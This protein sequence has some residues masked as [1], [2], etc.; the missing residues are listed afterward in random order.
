MFARGDE[1]PTCEDPILDPSTVWSADRSAKLRAAEQGPTADALDTDMAAWKQVRSRACAAPVGNREPRIACLDGVLA[2]MATIARAAERVHGAPNVDTGDLLIDPAVCESVRPPRLVHAGSD[3]LVDIVVAMLEQTRARRRMTR[4]EAKTL[5]SR[6][7]SEPCASAFANM[8]GLGDMVT[9]DRVAQ[10]DEAERAAQRCG[11]DRIVADI[12]LAAANWVIRDRLLDAQAP[13]KLRRAEAAAE[14]V[15]QPDLEA[16]LDMMRA[17]L[18]A[19]TD[20][21]DDAVTWT[22]KSARAYASRHR[23]R[24]EVTANLTSLGYR[25]LRGRAEDLAAMRDRLTA[26][27]AKSAAAFGDTDRQVKDIDRRLAFDEMSAGDVASA[28]AKLE[29][30]RDPAPIDKPVRV[31]GR[32]VD[33]QGNPVAGALVVGSSESYGDSI[34]VMIPNDD[35]RRATTGADG[36]FV[37]PEVPGEGIVVAQLGEL[38]SGAELVADSITLTLH[39]TSRI[40]GKV[41][42]HGQPA[43][44]VGVAV[45]DTRQ[46]VT[47]PYGIYTSLQPDGSFVL[48]GV[49]RGKVVVQTALTRGAT[50]RMIT[51]IEVSVDKPV[52]KGIA[53]ELKSSKRLVHVIVRS[54]YGVDLPAA[55]IVVLTGRVP[56]SN[57]LEIN[58][59]LRTAAVRAGMPILGEQAP[60]PVLAKAKLRDL[61]ATMTE[62]PEGEASACALGL[63]KDLDPDTGKKLQDPANLA[64]ISV[65]CVPIA[66]TDDVVVVEVLPWPRFD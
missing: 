30:L 57:A 48:E 18:A 52:V 19:R 2:R 23:T 24:M 4:D 11:D 32:V 54:Q 51:G 8:F 12:A 10:L 55:Q 9:T 44:S 35:E 50:T 27:R 61:Y 28:H 42:L 64:K 17:E 47:V 7:A 37:L 38:R 45:R 59:K 25:E 39:P 22:E 46:P 53:L 15:N 49:P 40:E 65:S 6:S 31:T 21:L 1:G 16:D 14:K 29:A 5:I 36:A 62:V 43:T 66:P 58:E 33:E 20:R 63:P 13:A 34:S 26:L 3:Q 56:S 60:K 41:E